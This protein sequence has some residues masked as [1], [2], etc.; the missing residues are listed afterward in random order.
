M[1]VMLS[2][3]QHQQRKKYTAFVIKIKINIK[4]QLQLFNGHS[5]NR[6]VD[7]KIVNFQ[8][9]KSD[10]IIQ[11]QQQQQQ[12]NNDGRRKGTSN[13]LSMVTF[14]FA[15]TLLVTPISTLPSH[16][17]GYESLSPE[18][19]FVAET[20][21][22]VDATYLDRTF[23][24][25]DWFQIRQD[26]VKKKYKNFEEAQMEVSNM[27]SKLGDKYTKVCPYDIMNTSLSLL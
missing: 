25:Q 23:N 27:M 24:G 20:W 11:Q 8:E 18:Q 10:R 14:A 13:I 19:K 9:E 21:R 6:I 16:A 15:T 7:D 26:L 5:E 1:L 22:T 17:A 3:C 12:P 4:S 2:N